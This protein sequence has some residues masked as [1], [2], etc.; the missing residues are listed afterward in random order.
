MEKLGIN[1]FLLI[2]QII[3]FVIVLFILK[4][5]L[6]KPIL[7]VLDKR[8]KQIDDTFALQNQL[9][10]EQVK[11]EESQKKVLKN[12]GEEGQRIIAAAIK[13]AK[14]E[15]ET[16]LTM[17]REEANTEQKKIQ[18]I[19]EREREK[20]VRYAKKQSL[21]FAVLLS[22]RLLGKSLSKDDQQRM[23]NEAIGDMKK[24]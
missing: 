6:Y 3:N 21:D 8:K 23:L 5:F 22:E 10:N 17:A 11:L 15:Q 18:E 24:V 2:T 20:M 4:K 7:E 19:L 16:I 1:W 12:A 13:E 14:K 9:Q